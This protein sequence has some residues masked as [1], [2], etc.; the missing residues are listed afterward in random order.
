MG[1]WMLA[2]IALLGTARPE[3][4]GVRTS[5][6]AAPLDPQERMARA[7]EAAARAAQAAAEA[8]GRAAAAAE[9]AAGVKAP[10]EEAPKAVATPGWTG[11][12]GAG[13]IWIAGNA[14]SL[15]FSANLALEKKTEDW[16]FAVKGNALYGQARLPPMAMDASPNA[17][18]TQVVALAGGLLLRGDRRFTKTVTGYLATGADADHVKSIEYRVSGEA[19]SGITWVEDVEG[20]LT[21]LLLRT[22]LGFRYAR[23]SRFQYYPSYKKIGDVDLA[24]PRL[25]V[26]FRYALNKDL[27]FTEDAEIL[28]NIIGDFRYLLNS[29]SKLSVRLT[30]I[31]SFA[32]SLQILHDSA[33]APGKKDTDGILTIGLELAL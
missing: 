10:A 20:D 5:T 19:G 30:Q 8:A 27:L 33:P 11:T 16:I 24:A 29:S 17:Q 7:M 6:S 18:Q 21:K 1:T 23:E 13:L 26:A 14:E 31:F 12:F 4:E 2:V 28:P 25:A 9:K 15:T 3:A 32:T 22:D